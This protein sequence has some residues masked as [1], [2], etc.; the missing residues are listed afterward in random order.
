MQM[1]NLYQGCK[2]SSNAYSSNF[3]FRA[4]LILIVLFYVPVCVPALKHMTHAVER[5]RALEY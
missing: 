5:K 2:L 4:S 3:F 1:E